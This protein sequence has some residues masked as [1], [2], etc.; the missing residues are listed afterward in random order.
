MFATVAYIQQRNRI[1][2][3]TRAMNSKRLQSKRRRQYYF[4]YTNDIIMRSELESH[5]TEP[6]TYEEQEAALFGAES[7]AGHT[8]PPL[9]NIENKQ[10][11]RIGTSQPPSSPASWTNT[12]NPSKVVPHQKKEKRKKK[13]KGRKVLNIFGC[14]FIWIFLKLFLDLFCNMM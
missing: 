6:M 11:N 9:D 7:N 3:S 5:S 12:M 8:Q 1:E 4:S 10:R 13:R 14:L 2:A